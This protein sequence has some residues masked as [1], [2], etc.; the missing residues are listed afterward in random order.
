MTNG[1]LTLSVYEKLLAIKKKVVEVILHGRPPKRKIS[2]KNPNLWVYDKYFAL[3]DPNFSV[4]KLIGISISKA[5]I[6]W[7]AISRKESFNILQNMKFRA[8][9]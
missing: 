5:R 1:H 7:V 6:E 3:R 4:T 8:Y 2:N 9:F